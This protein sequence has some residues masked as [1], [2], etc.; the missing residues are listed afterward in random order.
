[1]EA[2]HLRGLP[3]PLL[4]PEGWTTL[5]RLGQELASADH[6]QAHAVLDRID[7]IT[8]AAILGRQAQAGDVASACAALAALMI[9]LRQQRQ[10]KV[11]SRG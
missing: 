10:R 8:V 2:T 3:V 1:L 5:D 11:G 9:S 6:P 4:T 7:H